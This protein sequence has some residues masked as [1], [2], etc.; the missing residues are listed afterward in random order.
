MKFP[1]IHRRRSIQFLQYKTLPIDQHVIIITTIIILIIAISFYILFYYSENSSINH[2]NES[3]EKLI[4][5]DVSMDKN[6][7]RW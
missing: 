1:E 3:L 2:R 6:E 5:F 7:C 4:V